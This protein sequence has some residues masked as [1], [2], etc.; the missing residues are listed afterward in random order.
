MIHWII[1]LLPL[2]LFS[3]S[4]S[5]EEKVGQL[6]V[7]PLCPAREDH[8]LKDWEAMISESHIGNAILKH[9]DPNRQIEVL[10]HL[11][12]LA[13]IPLLVTADA[14]WGLAM[15][16]KETIAF[17]KNMTLGAIEDLPLI[18]EL[19]EEIGRQARL[20]GIHM[21]LA[22]VVDVNNNPKNPVI[23]MRSFGDDPAEVSAR[24]RAIIRGFQK[25]GLLSCAKHF[26]GHGNTAI[27]SHSDLPIISDLL[28]SIELPPFKEAIDSGVSAIMTAHILVPALDPIHP[29]TLSKTILTK[30][31]RDQLHF[32][33]LVITD[34]LNMKALSNRYSP[35]EIALKAHDAG[36]DLLLYGAHL[37]EDVEILIHDTIP[38]AYTA[39]LQAYREGKFPIEKLDRIVDRILSA[40]KDLPRNLPNNPLLNTDSAQM[41]KERL[42]QNAIVQIGN[43]PPEPRT[44]VSLRNL[45]RPEALD[46]LYQI[47]SNLVICL[48]ETPYAISLLPKNA[49]ILIAF[50][51][52]PIAEKV[53]GEIL[54]GTRKAKGRMPVQTYAP[55]FY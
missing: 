53:V 39:L 16:M 28:D 49:I 4:M 6:F 37:Y 26:P 36:A 50:E 3:A 8:H 40:K 21:N 11:Q 47:H 27:D 19:G 7:A 22:P 14:E 2:S 9:S 38:R 41:L 5:L 23:H 12:S 44:I 15:R 48:Y 31:L 10:N 52:D 51:E 25:A 30:L 35:E 55:N 1:Y 45:Y 13:K 33:G 46:E 43:L 32:D 54:D 18:E 20:V 34:A 24:A 17:P 42:Y 29:A